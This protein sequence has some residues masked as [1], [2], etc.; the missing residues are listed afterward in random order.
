[1]AHAAHPEDDGNLLR[2]LSPVKGPRIYAH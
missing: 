2:Y 1:L